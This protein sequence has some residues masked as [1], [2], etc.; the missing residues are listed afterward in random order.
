VRLVL[1]ALILLP[2]LWRGRHSSSAHTF[3]R[4]IFISAINSAIPFSLF[5]WAAQRAARGHWRDYRTRRGD[6]HGARGIRALRRA[7]H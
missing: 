6:V 1:G 2:L 4:S 7:H 5:A 3:C